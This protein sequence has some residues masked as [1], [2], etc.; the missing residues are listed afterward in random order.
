MMN[1]IDAAPDST[2]LTEIRWRLFRVDARLNDDLSR[3]L[4]RSRRI[5]LLSTVTRSNNNGNNNNGGNGNGNNNGNNNNDG[6]GNNNGNVNNNS[7]GYNTNNNNNN[8]NI[9]TSLLLLFGVLIT[10]LFV[11]LVFYEVNHLTGLLASLLE[12]GNIL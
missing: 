7:N 8:R 9:I 3:S 2:I 5:S 12:V 6:N 4:T 11:L 1:A 10:S